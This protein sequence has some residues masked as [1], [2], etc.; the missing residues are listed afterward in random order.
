MGLTKLKSAAQNIIGLIMMLL[1]ATS[2]GNSLKVGIGVSGPP[3]VEKAQTT[4][5]TVYF[6]FCVDIMNSICKKIGATC[7][8]Q[9]ITLDNQLEQLDKG[10]IDLLISV[11]PYT[12]LNVKHYAL[13]IPYSVSKIFF[14]TL[15]NSPINKV[16]DIKNKKIGVMKD[17]F[18]ELLVHSLYDKNNKVI[19]YSSE[20]SLLSDLAKHKVDVIALNNAVAF[21]LANNNIY[22]IKLIGKDIP[23]GDGYGIIA[24]SDKTKLIKQID[25]AILSIQN[26]GTYVSIYKKYYEVPD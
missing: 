2:F 19:A 1:A 9:D 22:N 18:Y 16:S 26:D 11:T 10:A 21:N 12:S 4:D 14:I 6:G 23:L 15:T 20:S 13:S 3:L 8:Y 7:T 17:T 5:G 25:D 24:L